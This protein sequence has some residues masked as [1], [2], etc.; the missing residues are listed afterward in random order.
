MN[1]IVYSQ[2][3][4]T[5]CDSLCGLEHNA[6]PIWQNDMIA[7]A[8][9]YDPPDCIVY[10]L[11]D[12]PVIPHDEVLQDIADHRIVVIGKREDVLIPYLA[13][14]GVK[15]FLFIPINPEDIV[16]RIENPAS[17]A[18]AAELLKTVPG[19]Q[20][21]RIIEII[22]AAPEKPEK[23]EKPQKDKPMPTIINHVAEQED[24]QATTDSNVG[25]AVAVVGD[26]LVIGIN[27]MRV[28][29]SLLIIIGAISATLYAMGVIFD[30]IN[31]NGTI[32]GYFIFFKNLINEVILT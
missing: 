14:L 31:L 4:E 15:D 1:I 19:L 11:R 26:S 18:E 30:F 28:I 13:G 21:E 22:E 25:S 3:A 20:P 10:D 7:T 16:H 5:Y 12:E 29:V 27:Y 24:L 8:V 23:P 6:R 17:P 9:A 2:S 32:P